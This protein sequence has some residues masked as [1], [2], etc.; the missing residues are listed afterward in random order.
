MADGTLLITVIGTNGPRLECGGNDRPGWALSLSGESERPERV[1]IPAC[2]DTILEDGLLLWMLH[3]AR[4][5]SVVLQ[6]KLLDFP[7]SGRRLELADVDPEVRLKLVAAC[8]ASPSGGGATILGDEA[9]RGWDQIGIVEEFAAN[10]TVAET[11]Y[12]RYD[13]PWGLI[14]HRSRSWPGPRKQA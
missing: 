11:V 4:A 13:D 7:L 3:A 12:Y 14:T 10:F 5:E 9:A 1:W 8:M 2:S 6:A